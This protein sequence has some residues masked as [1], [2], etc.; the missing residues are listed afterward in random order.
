MLFRVFFYYKYWASSQIKKSDCEIYWNILNSLK[1]KFNCLWDHF[2]DLEFSRFESMSSWVGLGPCRVELVWS[3]FEWSWFGPMFRGVNP[4][5]FRGKLTWADIKLSRVCFVWYQA[6]RA[7]TNVEPIRP[8]PMSSWVGLGS[9]RV[10][11]VRAHIEPSRCG[12]MLSRAGPGPCWAE[13]TPVHVKPNRSEPVSSKVGLG[14]CQDESVRAHV[15]LNW[16]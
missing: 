2:T 6:E 15:E 1:Y 13:P 14:P 11:S 8:G 5:R 7:W 4:G 9:C 10:E 16:S 3:L 12:P